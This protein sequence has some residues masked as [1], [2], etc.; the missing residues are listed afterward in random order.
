MNKKHDLTV[1]S[2]G[3]GVQSSVLLLMADQGL[4]EPKPDYALFADTG[5]EPFNVYTHL[6]W[7]ETQVSIPIIR[8]SNGRNLYDDT[9]NGVGS[10]GHRFTD[11]PVFAIDSYGDVQLSKRQCTRNYKIVPQQRKIRELLGRKPGVRTGPTAMQ[12]IGISCDEAMRMKPSGKSWIEHTWPLIDAG[13]TRV[14]C[15]RWFQAM[16]PGRPLVKSSC[17]GCPFHSDGQWL[18]LAEDMPEEMDRTIAL[19]TRLRS[20]ERPLNGNTKMLDEYLHKSAKPLGEVI[21]KLKR[22]ADEGQQA[23]WLKDGFGNECEGLCGV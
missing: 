13:M 9:W 21:A 14:D 23:S 1:L 4:I 17:V 15:L 2:L 19:D 16:Y 7:L 12:Q 20:P 10:S 11:I 18:Q 3:A 8:V 5:W 22:N 6:D